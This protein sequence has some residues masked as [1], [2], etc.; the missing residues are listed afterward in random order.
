MHIA[1]LNNLKNLILQKNSGQRLSFHVFFLK[2]SQKRWKS[3]VILCNQSNTI[4]DK[5]DNNGKPF[6]IY[7]YVN[8]PT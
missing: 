4:L 5:K 6:S 8:M 3:L 1:E 2:N 7:I